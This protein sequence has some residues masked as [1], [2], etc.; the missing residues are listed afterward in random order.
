MNEEFLHF[1]WQYQLFSLQDNLD[2]KIL[3]PGYHNAH[4]GPDFLHAKVVID[5]IE[6]NGHIE[7]HIKSSD[8]KKHNHDDNDHYKNVILHVVLEED[9]KLDMN[10]HTICLQGK[11]HPDINDQYSFWLQNNYDIPCSDSGL[12]DINE[13]YRISWVDRLIVERCD[14]K[15]SDWMDTFR[16]VQNNWR[17][18][19]WVKVSESFGMK[20]NNI[21]FRHLAMNIDINVLDR[22]DHSLEMIEAYLYGVSGLLPEDIQDDYSEQLRMN[23]SFIQQKF[24]SDFHIKMPWNFLRMRP[25]N[26]PTIRI[27][28][29]ARMLHLFTQF[30]Q[31][32]MSKNLSISDIEN[33]MNVEASTYWTEH[34]TFGKKSTT[35]IKKLGQKA[36]HNI[37]INAVIPLHYFHGK[38]FNDHSSVAH[39]F[40][41][42]QELKPEKNSIIDRWIVNNHKPSNAYE[43]QSYIHLYNNYC[44]KKRCASCQFGQKL[45]MEEN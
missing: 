7:I 13:L 21:G 24:Q 36:I 29:L 45:L 1:V 18:M 38:T 32:L 5:D 39:A 20:Y 26:F 15:Y 42:L 27:S 30:P 16:Q 28:Q 3:H 43:S 35:T 22:L 10:F 4:E 33:M 8:W 44:V 34:Y 2:I 14:A 23:Y 19:I 37:I 9:M 41:L 12:K 6:W 40:Q 11:I 25:A 31:N 17:Q